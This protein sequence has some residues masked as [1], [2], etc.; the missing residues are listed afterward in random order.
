MGQHEST[1]LLL[2]QAKLLDSNTPLE[3]AGNEEKTMATQIVTELDGLPLAL[4]QVGAYTEETHYGLPQYLELYGTRRRELLLRRGTISLDYSDSVVATWLLFFARVGEENPA[5]ADLL[6]LPAFL[7][8]EDI[9]DELIISSATGS[10]DALDMIASDRFLLNEAI[11]LVLRYSLIRRNPK[12]M[13]LSIHRL[14]QAVLRDS[15]DKETRCIWAERVIQFAALITKAKIFGTLRRLLGSE[16]H[17]ETFQTKPQSSQKDCGIQMVELLA[18]Q[19]IPAPPRRYLCIMQHRKPT[20]QSSEAN[21]SDARIR[22]FLAYSLTGLMFLLLLTY[23]L[24]RN[25]AILATTTIFAI[26]HGLVYPYYFRRER[27]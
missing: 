2:W 12:A 10:V 9:P 22:R 17:Q 7:H 20:N 19:S 4:D 1:L 8:P 11:E 6:R 13:P 14:V 21:E 25:D 16:S 27:N 23:L 3:L 26:A 18:D 15:M 24:T 5:E